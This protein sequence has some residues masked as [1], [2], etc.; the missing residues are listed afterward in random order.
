MYDRILVPLDGSKFSEE[1]LPYASGIAEPLGARV[2]LLRVAEKESE[3]AEADRYVQ[4][5]AST[6]KIEARTVV[7]RGSV[8]ADILEE[9]SRV[10]G[11]LVAITSH[12]RGGLLNA[13]LGSVAL[14]LVRSGRE[15]VLVFHPDG[16]TA[17]TQDPVRIKTVML[18][19]DGTDLSEWMQTQAAE[20]TRALKAN[21]LVVQAISPKARPDPLVPA[22]DALEHSY[23]R[24]HAMDLARKF[25]IEAG[26]EVLHGEPVDA[27][28]G[29]IEGR[30][31]VLVVMA[32][33]GRAA[34]KA[35][36]L[37]SVTAGLL[38]EGGVP[39]I[40]RVP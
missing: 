8:S 24:S 1:V 33:H 4:A 11:T 20:W 14:D 32:T 28:S 37:G 25:G 31:D 10:P 30:R 19:L 2:E 29:F 34:L 5:L 27:I 3:K 39:I 23:V 12:G 17:S 18:P 35:A 13:I 6:L 9:S 22:N 21:L 26:W 15:P 36:V 16:N 38:H 40:V 7:S